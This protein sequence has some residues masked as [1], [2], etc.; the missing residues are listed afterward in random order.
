MGFKTNDK[1]FRYFRN[2]NSQKFFLNE[3]RFFCDS[4][5]KEISEMLFLKQFFYKGK[6]KRFYC[7]S[8][9]CSK[10]LLYIGDAE[11]GFYNRTEFVDSDFILIQ[12]ERNDFKISNKLD[13]FEA[14]RLDCRTNDKTTF[15][16]RESLEG[17]FVGKSLKEITDQYDK[18][19]KPK[20][21]F[22]LLDDLANPKNLIS[23][24]KKNKK[25]LR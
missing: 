24:S 3:K 20:E 7:C 10:Q 18:D 12:P 21:A 9:K 1:D 8:V 13:L 22:N 25:L 4:C 6:V 17:A 15:A 2:K 5:E 19:L 14:S 16:G 23:N 11:I